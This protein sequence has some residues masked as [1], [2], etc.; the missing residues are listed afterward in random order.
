MRQP[1]TKAAGS[2]RIPFYPAGLA[3]GVELVH[4]LPRGC[5]D[6]L[7]GGMGERLDEL[8]SQFGSSLEENMSFEKAGKSS[9]IRL[10]VPPINAANDFVSQRQD[11]MIG[12][13]AVS[14]LSDWYAKFG[15]KLLLERDRIRE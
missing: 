3:K 1:L 14:R 2:W 8:K 11:V 13:A 9:S 10:L 4:S 5:V 7:F 15:E 12:I 6:L